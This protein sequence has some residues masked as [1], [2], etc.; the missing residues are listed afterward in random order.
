MFTAHHL[1]TLSKIV[2]TNRTQSITTNTRR[3]EGLLMS[4]PSPPPKRRQTGERQKGSERMTPTGKS[5]R[6]PRKNIGNNPHRVLNGL[7]AKHLRYLCLDPKSEPY[8]TV[9][10]LVVGYTTAH[11]RSRN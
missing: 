10:S 5:R 8:R 6:P 4:S 1:T 11:V 7:Y 9:N 3:G 2:L